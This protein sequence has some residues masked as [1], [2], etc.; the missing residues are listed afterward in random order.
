M[1]GKRQATWRISNVNDIDKIVT[2]A[3]LS[4]AR[5][6]RLPINALPYVEKII[7]SAIERAL[8]AEPQRK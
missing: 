3:A 1:E 4:I 8:T 7:K 5:T 6:W 2:A